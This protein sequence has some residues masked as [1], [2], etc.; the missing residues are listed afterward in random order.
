[1]I[2]HVATDMA[3]L[4]GLFVDV[5]KGFGDV[6]PWWRGQLNLSW[7]LVAGVY[8]KKIV[9]PETS[10]NVLYVSK[11]GSR[12]NNCPADDD[13]WGWLFLM[14]HY[15]LPTR[16]LDWSWS[17]L[18]ALFFAVDNPSHDQSDAAIWAIRPAHLNLDQGEPDG[19]WV[20]SKADFSRLASEAFV[21]SRT[22]RD[23]RTLAVATNESDPRHL[24]QQSAFTI[25][26]DG[27]PIN[28]LPGA[29]SFLTRIRIPADTKADFRLALQLLGIS[30]ASLFP[31]LQ[32]LA[33]DLE[34]QYFPYD[35][36]TQSN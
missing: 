2:E 1:M 36:L 11:A 34:S 23:T 16:L 5:G 28:E 4:T 27:T 8:R 21:Q 33:R 19:I 15:G 14:Q 31:D 35:D 32:N 9:G 25:H 20:A 18:V 6:L 10:L 12:Y 30:R 24:V 3:Q 13:F 17:P 7:N 26:G 29:E 22:P